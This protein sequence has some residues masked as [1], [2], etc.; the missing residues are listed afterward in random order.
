MLNSARERGVTLIELAI[1]MVIAAVLAMLAAP[2]IATWMQDMRVRTSAEA[3]LN[4]LQT[5][6]AEGVARNTRVRFQLTS[7]AANDC[8]VSNTGTAWAV[9][10][11]PALTADA[12]EGHCGDTPNDAVAPRLLQVRGPADGSIGAA[13]NGSAASVVFDGLGR[14][15]AGTGN[16]S[17]DISY[18]AGGACAADGGPI[19]CLRV[20]VTPQGLLRMCNPKL[21][22]NKPDDPRAC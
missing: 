7:S 12:V 9:N 3:I 13:V 16:V 8:V 4:G 14:P 19:A 20:L 2:S 10:V 18:P 5:A 1:T 6:K 11:D 15:M 17:I 22:Q 21:T